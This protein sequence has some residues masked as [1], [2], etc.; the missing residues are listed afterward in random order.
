MRE[1]KSLPNLKLNVECSVN[2]SMLLAA[3]P[4][5]AVL[6]ITGFSGDP[7]CIFLKENS[8]NAQMF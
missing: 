3:F 1:L 2:P 8:P 5:G 7:G 6:I 4:V